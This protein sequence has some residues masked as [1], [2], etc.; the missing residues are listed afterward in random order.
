[1]HQAKL[2]SSE[3]P[4]RVWVSCG[5]GCRM[6]PVPLEGQHYAI[7]KAVVAA[8]LGGE[9]YYRVSSSA[10]SGSSDPDLDEVSRLSDDVPVTLLEHAKPCYA[11]AGYGSPF[12]FFISTVPGDPY[13]TELPLMSLG[14]ARTEPGAPLEWQ[15]PG[16]EITSFGAYEFMFDGGWGRVANMTAVE[17]DVTVG[18][19]ALETVFS[20]LA[21]QL[22]PVARGPLVAWIDYSD[23]SMQHRARVRSW[24]AAGG[25][26]ELTSGA[27]DAVQ[28]ALSDGKLVWMEASG[29]LSFQGDYETAQLFWSPPATSPAGVEAHAGPFVPN[30]W[31]MTDRLAT[32]GDLAAT[33]VY[34]PDHS[35]LLVANVVTGKTWII[36]PRPCCLFRQVMAMNDG[37]LLL[38][39]V[40]RNNTSHYLDRLVRLDLG[41]LDELA[42]GPWP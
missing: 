16:V 9:I 36:P 18:V 21:Y 1:V 15:L 25:T 33:I 29:P 10:G 40:D 23:W 24:T 8:T 30:L 13:A 41:K 37:A 6:A 31:K 12:L 28:V 11:L 26:V 39:E 22:R 4:R 20:S 32:A 19:A 14:L 35:D 3:V 42:T 17:V 2:P 27:G 7:G 5:S 34:H 38:Q